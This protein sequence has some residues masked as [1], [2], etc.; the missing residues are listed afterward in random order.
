[1]GRFSWKFSL[2]GKS[3]ND[4]DAKS[5]VTFTVKKDHANRMG[6]VKVSRLLRPGIEL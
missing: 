4:T 6:Q 1:M 3:Q 2:L 5:Y